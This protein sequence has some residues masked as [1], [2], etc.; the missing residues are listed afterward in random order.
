RRRLGLPPEG[1]LIGIVGRLQRS[2]GMHVLVE[3]LPSVLRS[4]PDAQCVVVGGSHAAEAD[5]PAYLQGRIAALDLGQRVRCVGWQRNIPEWVQAMD[6]IVSAT[7]GEGFGMAIVEAMALGK[8][9]VAG[10]TGGPAEILTE[11]VTGL[12]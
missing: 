1:P 4:Y 3:A 10:N 9:V 8:P 11:G 7:D 2:K 6:V 5:Y 12:L